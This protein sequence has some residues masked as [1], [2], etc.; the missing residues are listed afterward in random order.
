MIQG[1][2]IS[3]SGGKGGF[4]IYD[5]TFVD[6]SFA[7]THSCAGLLSMANCG[8]NT[9]SSQFFITL[10]AC[11]HLDG[12]H[13]V[14]GQVIDGMEIVKKI[15]KVRIDKEDK[16]RYPIVIIDCGAIDDFRGFLRYD[17]FKKEV[18]QQIREARERII[19]DQHAIRK[20]LSEGLE[21]NEA[22]NYKKRLEI[23]ERNLVDLNKRE[24]Q[25]EY[26]K[27]Q[28]NELEV[29]PVISQQDQDNAELAEN[30]KGKLKE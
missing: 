8:R 18:F 10:K 5:R 17:P 15:S 2:D 16:P 13:V 14:F 7:R 19:R 25:L 20:L 12:K 27:E 11:P 4:S 6:E 9:N 22:Y 23:C 21:P 28:E 3:N 26:E 24:G 30:L 1:G 29:E